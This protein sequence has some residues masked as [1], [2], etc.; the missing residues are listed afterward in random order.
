MHVF[1]GIRE[2]QLQKYR[3]LEG[4]GRRGTAAREGRTTKEKRDCLSGETIEMPPWRAAAAGPEHIEHQ[5]SN[6]RKSVHIRFWITMVLSF[7]ISWRE[8]P[9]GRAVSHQHRI[10]KCKGGGDASRSVRTLP[11]PAP[12]PRARAAPK[13]ATVALARGRREGGGAVG[14]RLLIVGVDSISP[15]I[16]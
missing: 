4:K 13:A 11:R 9:K 8:I 7:M 6:E 15:S 14:L 10:H 5:R 3:R 16:D 12:A 2:G 1:F